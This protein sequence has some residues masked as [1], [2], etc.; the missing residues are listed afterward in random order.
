MTLM[1]TQTAYPTLEALFTFIF[2]PENRLIFVVIYVTGDL[3]LIL[4][5]QMFL[6]LNLYLTSWKLFRYVM[7][8]KWI[9]FRRHLYIN[10][11]SSIT[12]HRAWWCIAM[13]EGRCPC[14]HMGQG[15]TTRCH[16]TFRLKQRITTL[17]TALYK[18]IPIS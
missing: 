15:V 6:F 7:I 14:E 18:A 1:T 13:L 12:Y 9:L 2:G 11:L 10:L 17:L 8:S 4:N 5:L 3:D 16:A